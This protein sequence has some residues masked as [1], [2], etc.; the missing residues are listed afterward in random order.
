MADI[1]YGYDITRADVM[2][3]YG[4]TQK[5]YDSIR[6]R[7]GERITN[8]KL[9]YLWSDE[10]VPS[11]PQLI[12]YSLKKRKT[13]VE[14]YDVILRTATSKGGQ[15]SLKSRKEAVQ[16]F[17]GTLSNVYKGFNKFSEGILQFQEMRENAENRLN[18]KT[19]YP[20]VMNK[21]THFVVGKKFSTT[22]GYYFVNNDVGRQVVSEINSIIDEYNRIIDSSTKDN[23]LQIYILYVRRIMEKIHYADTHDAIAGSPD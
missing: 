19:K 12:D 23:A 2:K 1:K 22:A 18:E 15:L 10:D 13:D 20:A 8:A 7:V 16:V 5:Q 21:L 3:K 14:R 17:S 6:R 11:I 4:L 9:L